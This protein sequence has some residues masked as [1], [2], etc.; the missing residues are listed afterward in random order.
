MVLTQTRL[1]LRIGVERSVG[2][3]CEAARQ[4]NISK[5]LM[6]KILSGKR[7]IAPDIARRFS[8][9]HPLNA[10]ALAEEIT[11]YSCFRYDDVDRHP[12]A[13]LHRVLKEDREADRAMMEIPERIMGKRGP[14][15]L[16]G[17]DLIFLKWAVKELAER[18]AADLNLLI[19]IEDRYR[20]GVWEVV[21][22][23]ENAPA[24]AA[25][26][27]EKAAQQYAAAK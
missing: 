11:G 12:L 22:G 19:E 3:Q 17:D 20:I 9:M 23:K 5:A 15:D 18:V 25:R 14:E 8:R 10:L 4:M 21:N 6:S 7:N 13:L 24:I 26:A 2:E 27:K 1:L 16:E